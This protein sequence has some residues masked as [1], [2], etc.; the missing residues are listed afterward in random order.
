MRQEMRT[1]PSVEAGIKSDSTDGRA[2]VVDYQPGNGTRYVLVLTS[3][4]GHPSQEKVLTREDQCALVWVQ[5]FKR[6]WIAGF[7]G[8][9][10]VH[11]SDIQ[12]HL[13]CS[14]MDAVSLAEIIGFLLNRPCVSVD[15]FLREKNA[16]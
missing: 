10:L 16:V 9:N 3:L 8:T 11:Y 7:G 1:K 14:I 6:G 15:D 12:K 2:R 5:N 4:S 13:G